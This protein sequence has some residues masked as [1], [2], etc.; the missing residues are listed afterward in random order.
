MSNSTIGAIKVRVT[1]GAPTR[2][3]SVQYSPVGT[4]TLKNAVDV[5]IADNVTDR[6]VLTYNKTT[7]QF[8][9][10]DVPRIDGGTY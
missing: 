7:E 6:A 5:S 8:V 3:Q 1:N 10:Q 2:V 9:A 4:V